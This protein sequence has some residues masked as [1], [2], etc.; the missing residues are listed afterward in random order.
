MLRI[1]S[2]G[3]GYGCL[4]CFLPVKGTCHVPIGHGWLFELVNASFLALAAPGLL[5]AATRHAFYLLC[6]AWHVKPCR[7][8]QR[9]G[10]GGLGWLFELVNASFLA[11]AAPRLQRAATRHAFYLLCAAVQAQ[12][13]SFPQLKPASTRACCFYLHPQLIRALAAAF[14]TTLSAPLLPNSTRASTAFRLQR[15]Q[16]SSAPN[17]VTAT[18]SR[19]AQF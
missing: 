10:W 11:L 1:V 12:R 14:P 9:G 17:V 4:S 16:H 15:L 8:L 7:T 3:G 13:G 5:R 19:L 2:E 6:A 18:N